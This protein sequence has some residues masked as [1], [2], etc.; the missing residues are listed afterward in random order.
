MTNDLGALRQNYVAMRR[1]YVLATSK[2]DFDA[3]VKAYMA[4]S[5]LSNDPYNY[6]YTAQVIVN[7]SVPCKECGVTRCPDGCCCGC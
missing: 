1:Q 6:I 5:K 7:V 4:K 2:F 3:R